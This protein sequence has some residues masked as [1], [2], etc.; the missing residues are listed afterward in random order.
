MV[1]MTC[2]YRIVISITVIK[3]YNQGPLPLLYWEV[4]PDSCL[5]TH[6]Y[7]FMCLFY[8][9]R[10]LIGFVPTT[11]MFV[12]LSWQ[13]VLLAIAHQKALLRKFVCTKPS[14]LET[15]L[16]D[17]PP[18]KGDWISQGHICGC[19]SWPHSSHS[20]CNNKCKTLAPCFLEESIFSV[21]SPMNSEDFFFLIPEC[22]VSTWIFSS[23]SLSLSASVE[24]ARL[25]VMFLGLALR[26][27]WSILSGARG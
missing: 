2:K 11:S 21:I 5:W 8:F 4:F 13:L 3:P 15:W 27:R 18:K 20:N 9:G 26:K 22:L 17:P 1:E 23:P 24:Q 14:K 10:W 16:R 6:V 19:H 7:L 12:I 25:L